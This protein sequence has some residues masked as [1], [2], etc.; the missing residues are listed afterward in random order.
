MILSVRLTEWEKATLDMGGTMLWA[1]GESELGT[2]FL[3]SQLPDSGYLSLL[4][5]HTPV[6][7]MNYI[8]GT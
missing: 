4:L 3:G 1:T 7:G 8:P 5:P 6:M 2:G